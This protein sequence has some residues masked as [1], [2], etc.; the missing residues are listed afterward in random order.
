MCGNSVSSP[1]L[2]R[3]WKIPLKNDQQRSCGHAERQPRRRGGDECLILGWALE[4]ASKVR[5]GQAVAAS[6]N[7]VLDRLLQEL[8]HHDHTQH[9]PD[10]AQFAK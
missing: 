10:T 8:R 6:C 5:G 7:T 4:G 3:S 1:D 2:S 9:S